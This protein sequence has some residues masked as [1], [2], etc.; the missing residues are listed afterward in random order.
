[1]EH[2]WKVAGDDHVGLG[3]DYDGIDGTPIGLEDVTRIPELIRRLELRGHSG[4]RLE[5]FVGGN[6]CGCFVIRSLASN[7][8]YGTH[9]AITR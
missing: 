5:K 3:T 6:F 4:Q 1:M 8:T 7:L 9:L 2:F